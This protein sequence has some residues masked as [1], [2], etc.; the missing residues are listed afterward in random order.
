VVPCPLIVEAHFR[1]S[2]PAYAELLGGPLGAR[3]QTIARSP[4]SF[5]L[6]LEG[7]FSL[8]TVA[9]VRPL[10]QNH[11][12]PFSILPGRFRLGR[13][14]PFPDYFSIPPKP[15]RINTY[16]SVTKQRTLTFFRMNTYE[17]HRG[18]GVLLLTTNAMPLYVALF[19]PL[20]SN[21]KPLICGIIPRARGQHPSPATGRIQ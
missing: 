20:T 2:F 10:A 18:E 5:T 9:T 11:D 12:R 7:L 8:H 14:G 4:R 16:K 21:V 3:P 13:K 15:F 1:L 17:K 6:S 19:Q